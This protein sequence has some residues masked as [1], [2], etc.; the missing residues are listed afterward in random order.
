M[1]AT[2]G[3]VPESA[4]NVGGLDRKLRWAGGAALVAAGV[5]VFATGWTTAGAV[6]V[7][8]GV[9]LLF[10]AVTGFCVMNALLGV[11]TCSKEEC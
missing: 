4:R 10:N 6:A 8:T 5:A 7:L 9:G 1:A 11:D 3:L 2:D